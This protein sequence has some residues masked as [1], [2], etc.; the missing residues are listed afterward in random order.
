MVIIIIHSLPFE[1]NKLDSGKNSDICNITFLFYRWIPSRI[2]RW[3]YTNCFIHCWSWKRVR[4]RCEVSFMKKKTKTFFIKMGYFLGR[5]TFH[6]K[7]SINISLKVR[8]CRTSTWTIS[9]SSSSSQAS[10]TSSSPSISPR[11]S[12]SS[13]TLSC[14]NLS[15]KPGKRTYSTTA[16]LIYLNLYICCSVSHMPDI[17]FCF[18]AGC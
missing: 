15:T 2:T 3:S 12:I 5:T 14:L 7:Y 17:Y 11:A 18:I 4:R 8:R 13:S 6:C 1:D 9:S 16:A 10:S